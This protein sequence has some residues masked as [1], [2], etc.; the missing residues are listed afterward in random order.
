MDAT[1]SVVNMVIMKKREK[2][3]PVLTD[4]NVPCCQAPPK[5]CQNLQIFSLSKED[6]VCQCVVRKPLNKEGR[7][8]RIKVLNM[9]CLVTPRILQ[10]KRQ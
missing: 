1:L 10:D 7:K 6:G 3:I 8:S 2:D 9:Q 5:S 4:T